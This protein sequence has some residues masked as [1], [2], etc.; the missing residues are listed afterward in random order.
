MPG[1]PRFPARAEALPAFRQAP[2]ID[3][4]VAPVALAD[5]T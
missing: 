1:S 5:S 2:P 3:G 4:V